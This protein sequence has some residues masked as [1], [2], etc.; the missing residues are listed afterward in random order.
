MGNNSILLKTKAELERRQRLKTREGIA[1]PFSM[2]E[3]VQNTHQN[4]LAGWFQTILYYPALVAVISWV[5]AMYMSLLFDWTN[6]A[7]LFGL[8]VGSIPEWVF[9]FNL[10]Q[11]I[12][13]LII[14]VFFFLSDFRKA[15]NGHSFGKIDQFYS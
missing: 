6:P 13:T 15:C 8:S 10:T 12:L 4:Y 2:L 5:G 1:K 7:L 11:W 3:L 14:F 9:P